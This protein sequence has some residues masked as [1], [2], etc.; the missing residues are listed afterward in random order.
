MRQ[1]L[2]KSTL[3]WNIRTLGIGSYMGILNFAFVSRERNIEKMSRAG[4]SRTLFALVNSTAA[5]PDAAAINSST[6]LSA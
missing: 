2:C 6:G 1:V 5:N 4:C 3:L